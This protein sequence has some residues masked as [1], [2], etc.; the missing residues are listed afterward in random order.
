MWAQVVD[1]PTVR[2]WNRIEPILNSSGDKILVDTPPRAKSCSGAAA[3]HDLQLSQLPFGSFTPLIEPQ[4]VC[5]FDWSGKTPL[6]FTE[7]LNRRVTPIATGTAHAVF[8]WWDL[9]MDTEGKV[10][11]SCAP[12][13]E[14][15]DVKEDVK[16]GGS[17]EELSEK[18]PWR[19]HWMQAVYYF[20]K[21]VEVS[22]GKEVT[23]VTSHD[24][25]SFWYHLS[26]ESGCATTLRC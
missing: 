14:H 20:S 21:D 7:S 6:N 3:V 25:Y 18:I 5:R 10:L 24:E 26:D 11:L 16:N 8:M 17:V 2:A 15:P 23:L 4:A 19:D 22:A 12:V 9:N 1:S 13:W